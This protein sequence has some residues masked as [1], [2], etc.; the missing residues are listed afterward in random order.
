MFL[1]TSRLRIILF[2]R[3]DL[4]H[5]HFPILSIILPQNIVLISIISS[6]R[7]ILRIGAF[8]LWSITEY[9]YN[10]NTEDKELVNDM[11]INLSE[12]PGHFDKFPHQ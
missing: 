8:V 1:L 7:L 9:E 4:K 10:N 2:T 12:T 3:Q 6:E 11:K 5:E